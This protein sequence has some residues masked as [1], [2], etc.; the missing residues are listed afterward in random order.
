MKT[1]QEKLQ[2]YQI[3]EAYQSA[4]EVVPVVIGPLRIIR[5]NLS[6]SQDTLRISIAIGSVKVA[7]LL[8]I[9]YMLQKVLWLGAEICPSSKS[10]SGS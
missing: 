7:I 9:A 6:A 3:G 10:Q 5:K 8:G 2:R 1:E 4:A